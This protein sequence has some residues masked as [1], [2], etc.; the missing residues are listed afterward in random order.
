MKTAAWL[1][2]PVALACSAQERPDPAALMAAQREAMAR[3]AF[4]DGVGRGTAST[5]LPSG[6]KHD[7]TQTDRIGPLLG[8]VFKVI[9]GRGYE[10]DG[11]TTFNALGIIS[12]DVAKRA[13]SMRSYAMGYAGDFPVTLTSTGNLVPGV[14]VVP[15]RSYAS[16]DEIV[17]DTANARIWAGLH[18]RTADVQAVELG[19]NVA[20]Y[21][22]AKYFQ[23]VDNH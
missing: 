13:Y 11:K 21:A 16:L 7:I 1:L 18:F 20:N 12:Y 6:Q 2:L 10:P 3:L 17:D 4:M 5:T 9:E 15:T 22:A 14:P 23:P 19:T 8:G